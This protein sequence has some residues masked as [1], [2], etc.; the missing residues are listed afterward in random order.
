MHR[1]QFTV[2]VLEVAEPKSQDKQAVDAVVLAYCPAVQ[3]EQAEAPTLL[4]FFPTAQG[5]HELWP[6]ELWKEPVG[7][8]TQLIAPC[9]ANEPTRQSMHTVCLKATLWRPLG[10]RVQL[11]CPI[12]S[13]KRPGS[14]DRQLDMAV[15]LLNVPMSQAGQMVAP[16]RLLAVPAGQLMQLDLPLMS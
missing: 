6:S 10:Q 9:N 15:T 11:V 2:P 7:Q 5:V 3:T 13:W 4:D 8:L 16:G 12:M 1:S 14:H